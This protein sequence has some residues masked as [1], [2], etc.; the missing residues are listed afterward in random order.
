MKRSDRWYWCDGCGKWHDRDKDQGFH[1]CMY[2]PL[3]EPDQRN[4]DGTEEELKRF[5]IALRLR[6]EDARK[7]AEEF[8]RRIDAEPQS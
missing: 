1:H 4:F 7:A 2:C 8:E 3:E 5:V 6:R